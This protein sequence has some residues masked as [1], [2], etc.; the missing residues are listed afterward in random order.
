MCEGGHCPARGHKGR[1]NKSGEGSENERKKSSKK[2]RRS[3]EG[4]AGPERGKKKERA[5][6]Q[7]HE[8]RHKSIS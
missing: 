8:D 1:V 6:A 5:I 3:N 2:K 7:F 4:P